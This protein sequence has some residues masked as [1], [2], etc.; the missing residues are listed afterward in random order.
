MSIDNILNGQTGS[1]IVEPVK[2]SNGLEF[3]VEE[4]LGLQS[5]NP[6]LVEKIQLVK[7]LDVDFTNGITAKANEVR[8]LRTELETLK[9]QLAAAPATQQ[10][11]QAVV[12]S[13]STMSLGDKFAAQQLTERNFNRALASARTQFGELADLIAKQYSVNLQED[14]EAGNYNAPFADFFTKMCLEAI[15]VDPAAKAKYVAHLGGVTPEQVA[16]ATAVASTVEAKLTAPT[17]GLPAGGVVSTGP[18]VDPRKKVSSIKK[19]TEAAL[20][21]FE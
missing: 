11:S 17:T 18:A 6:A 15:A 7:K 12:P 14:F 13:G 9:A 16:A 1:P 20:S 10:V 2:L 8:V 3:T 4:L 19:A 5:T 21:R